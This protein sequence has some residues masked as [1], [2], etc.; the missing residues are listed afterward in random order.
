MK[1]KTIVTALIAAGAMSASVGV[2][3]G[4]A[5]LNSCCTPADKDFPKAG[6]NLGNQNYSSLTQIGKSNVKNLGPVWMTRVSAAPATTPAPSPGDNGGGQQTAPIVVDGVIYMDTPIGDVIAIDGATGAVKWK[7]HSTTFGPVDG[8]RRGVAVGDGKVYTLAAGDRVVALDKDTGAEVW[9]KQPVDANGESLGNIEKVA[10]VYYDGM[11][12]VGTNDA[13]RNAIFALHSSTG[14]M[15][16]FFY[17]ANKPETYDPRVFIDVNGNEVRADATSWGP[18]PSCPTNG[19]VAPWIHG[20]ID[21]EL[22]TIIVAFGNPR[23]CGSSQDGSTRPGDNL[24]ANTLVSLDAKTGAF[25][26]HYQSIRHDVWDMDNTHAPLLADVNVD[27]QLRKIVFYGSK[28]GHIFSIDRTNGKPVTAVQDKARPVDL[29][30]LNATHQKFPVLGRVV[31]ECLTWEKLDPNNIPGNPWRG[32]P[33][34]NGYRPDFTGARTSAAQGNLAYT[35]P[36]YLEPDKPFVT[37][38]AEYGVNHR[39]GCM[40][41]THWDLPVLSTTSQNGGMDW[42]AYSFSP[43]LNAFYI[44]Y[45]INPVAHWRGAG[46]NGQRALGQYQS[47]GIAAFDGS[48]TQL[49]WNKVTGLDMAHGQGPVATASDLLFIGQFDGNALALDAST[50]NELWRFQTGAAISSPP[51]VYSIDGEQ[52]VAFFAGGTGIP[53][54]NSVTNSDML[55]AFKLGGQLKTASGSQENPTP[56]PL[57]LRRPVGG[58]LVEG[59]TLSPPNTV[60]LARASR[61]A[62]TSANQADATAAGAM[63]PTQMR[64]PVGTT[65]TF[66]NPGAATFPNFPNTKPHCATQYFEGLFNFV[67]NAGEAATYTFTR[68]GEY[69][70]NDCTDPRPT[71]KIVVYAV[72][73]DLPGALR[74]VPS[75]INM[76]SPNGVFT[77]VQGLMTAVLDVPAGYTLDGGVRLKTPLSETEFKPVSTAVSANGKSLVVTFD[78]AL[79]DNNV[80]AGASVPLTLTANFQ[81]AGVQKQLTSTANVRIIK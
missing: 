81:S 36:N 8:D 62:D 23:E 48:S 73:E 53:Y 9:V 74:F 32:V 33:N 22:R 24:F 68:E 54:G 79:I 49:K 40:Y 55:W 57:N 75:A 19:G 61:T 11:V 46:G 78:K 20:A 28:S 70:F 7:W 15:A 34:Y 47:G 12:Y 76:R 59:S 80:P 72:P 26:W 51:V 44:P 14:E 77:G 69:F 27:G 52:Y 31:P 65:V 25:K 42:S 30:Q 17:G 5:D 6:G 16:W 4:A 29:R 10:T 2:V 1:V 60:F 18:D 43:K 63:N 37:I 41:D 58:Q 64:V 35:E 38:P 21:P 56:R 13:D 50:G 71:G 66:L 45:G 39:K 3:G 67:V